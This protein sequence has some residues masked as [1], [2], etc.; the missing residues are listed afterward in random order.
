MCI[1]DRFICEVKGYPTPNI[2]WF[3]QSFFD[4]EEIDLQNDDPEFVIDNVTKAHEGY[5]FCKPNNSY[6]IAKSR[7]AKLDVLISELPK[8]FIE[9]SIDIV[10]KETF[11]NLNTTTDNFTSFY[12]EMAGMLRVSDLQNATFSVISQKGNRVK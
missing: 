3:H 11:F 12:E 5:Y 8:Q 1:R 4:S 10:D 7:P 9:M 2:S 6:G